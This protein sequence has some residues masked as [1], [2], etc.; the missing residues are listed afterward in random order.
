MKKSIHV[1]VSL[2]VA[3]VMLTSCTSSQQLTASQDAAK[4]DVTQIGITF[5]TFVFERWLRDR[6]VFVS[7]A[8]ELGAEVNVQ[9]ANGDSDEQISQ[10][11]YFIDK[12]VDVIV[13]VAVE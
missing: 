12:K 3:L 13:I 2:V 10:I 1:C 6:D 11:Q 7:R 5:D 9:N 8:E 4:S